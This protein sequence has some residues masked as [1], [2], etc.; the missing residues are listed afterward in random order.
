MQRPELEEFVRRFRPLRDVALVEVEPD[1]FV[2]EAGLLI[3]HAAI[4]QND[5]RVGRIR[6]VGPGERGK[7]G[8]TIQHEYAVGDRVTFPRGMAYAKLVL[9]GTEL[10]IM[11][12]EQLDGFT[13]DGDE[14]VDVRYVS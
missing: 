3:G 7:R 5:V 10:R 12:L 1:A 14:R 8:G 9:N 13:I 6:A 11:K 2:S 4:E